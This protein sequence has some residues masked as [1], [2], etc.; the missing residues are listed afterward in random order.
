[1][2]VGEASATTLALVIH[3]LATNSLK[4]GALSVECGT[5]DVSGTGD[6]TEDV[7][8]I[9]TERG[10]PSVVAPA[11]A[12]YGSELVTRSMST[13]LRGSLERTWS[14]EGLTATLQMNRHRLA[15]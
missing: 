11:E 5:L 10:G 7:V 15:T 4:Y 12:G 13:Q 9:W 14:A 2:G 1:M 3:E 8:I 6:D